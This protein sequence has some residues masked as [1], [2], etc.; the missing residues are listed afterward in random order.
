M[1][2]SFHKSPHHFCLDLIKGLC[3]LYEKHDTPAYREGL[4][5]VYQQLMK[6][7]GDES[8]QNQTAE[9]LAGL[10]QKLDRNVEVRGYTIKLGA[11]KL[12]SFV[13]LRVGK[14]L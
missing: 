3:A 10:Y 11:Q 2:A 12:R 1:L 6:L 4:V 5:N 7:L 8:K 13:M 14:P 9:K